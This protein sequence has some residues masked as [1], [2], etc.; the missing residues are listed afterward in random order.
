MKRWML[1]LVSVCLLAPSLAFCQEQ[2][3]LE[4]DPEYQMQL[5][6]MEMQLQAREAK[7]EYERRMAELE[8]EAR[9]MQLERE[10]EPDDGGPMVVVLLLCGVVHLLVG[11]WIY[12]DIRQRNA[13][14]GL[15]I[16][17]GLLAGLIA[18][19]VYAV[20]RLGDDDTGKKRANSR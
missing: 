11:V 7:M 15:W 8:L 13:G 12:Q 19:L 14:S 10:M 4:G 6:E 17:L 5:R 9:K 20:V 16:V 18:A 2:E 3:G 1:C